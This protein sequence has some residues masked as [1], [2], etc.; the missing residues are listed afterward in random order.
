MFC[1]NCGKELPSGADV[2]LNCGKMVAKTGAQSNDGR[3]VIALLL[4]LFGGW[5]GFHRFYTG[6]IL[7]GVAQLLTLGGFGIWWLID[8]IMIVTNGFKDKAGLPLRQ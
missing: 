2:C 1:S 3:F 4:C 5:G 6:H 8:L 7:S